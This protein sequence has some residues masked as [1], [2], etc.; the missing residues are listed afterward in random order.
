MRARSIPAA[1]AL[2]ACLAT[3]GCATAT[4]P[5][6]ARCSSQPETS[7]TGPALV[8]QAYGMAMTPLPLNSVQFGSAEAARSLA[9]Q[10]L[11]AE[12]S[13][14]D[15][16]LISARLLSCSD[17]PASVRVRTAFLRSN[18]APAEE[19]S[20]WRTVYLEPRATALYQES[21]TS[22]DAVSYLIEIAK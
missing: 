20:A 12:R 9:V 19:P 14:T 10:S 22:R 17:V 15:L 13:A 2:A 3:V 16:V 7:R 8:G 4:P 11:Y 5:V 1:A 6:V 21:S 18:T